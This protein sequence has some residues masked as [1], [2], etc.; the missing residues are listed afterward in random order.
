MASAI[1]YDSI[2]SRSSTLTD[3]TTTGGSFTSSDVLSDESRAIDGNITDVIGGW[4]VNEGLQFNFGGTVSPNFCAIYSTVATTNDI[5]I[6]RDNSASGAFNGISNTIS[7]VAVG[8][9]IR[10]L[11]VLPM[12]YWTINSSVG[13]LNGISEIFFGEKLTFPV[14][15]TANIITEHNFGSEEVK[16]LGANRFYV[17]KHNNYKI[18]TLSLDYM[19]SANK[20]SME[21]FAN[22]VTDREPFIYSEDD[23]TGPFHWVRLV[24]PLTFRQVAPDIFSCQ[25]VMRELTS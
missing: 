8:W 10:T 9:N 25:V 16:A 20:A 17:S 19:T 14:E 21:T 5:I 11:T 4:A 15:P 6:Q 18:I 24:R 2:S 1:Y 7:D 13:S 3:G 22:T 23:T 12:Q